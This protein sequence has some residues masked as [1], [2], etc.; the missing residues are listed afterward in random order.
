MIDLKDTKNHC[1]PTSAEGGQLQSA[2]T[3]QFGRRV[4]FN[5]QFERNLAVELGKAR[6]E[7][8]ISQARMKM[9]TGINI[10]R[11]ES[12]SYSIELKTYLRI[13]EYLK[14]DCHT[15]LRNVVERE[16]THTYVV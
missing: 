7:K 2:K 1:S 9:D 10:A 4:Q 12:G 11:I 14:V 6:K 8:G 15:I 13:C 16:K 5:G 3:G